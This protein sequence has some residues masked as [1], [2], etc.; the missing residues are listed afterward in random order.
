MERTKDWLDTVHEAAN[1]L[2]DLA[3]AQ[4]DLARCF[5]RTGNAMIYDSLHGNALELLGIVKELRSALNEKLT[6]D[7]VDSR[8]RLELAA[9]VV[10][11]SAEEN[12]AQI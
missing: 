2:I 4:E 9:E 10:L 5:Q 3:A 6:Q 7:T 8:E 11:A 12:N 1:A